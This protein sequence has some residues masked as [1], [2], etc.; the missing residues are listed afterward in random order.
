[1]FKPDTVLKLG[2]HFWQKLYCFY[3][4]AHFQSLSQAALHLN[5][6]KSSVTKA[7]QALESRFEAVL[8][9]RQNRYLGLTKVGE[10]VFD[11]MQG[12]LGT[13]GQIQT[14]MEGSTQPMPPQWIFKIPEWVFCDYLFKALD[15][16]GQPF[17]D[18]VWQPS[19]PEAETIELVD[20]SI[21]FE[22]K[23]SQNPSLIQK[24]LGVFESGIYAS[25]R[26]LSQQ[27]IPLSLSDLSRHRL[28]GFESPDPILKEHLNWHRPHLGFDTPTD[29][30]L[31]NHLNLI[32]VAE[33]DGGI[34]AYFKNHPT[35]QKS[36][37]V[38]ILQ[39]HQGPQ[40]TLYFSCSTSLWRRLEVQTF[41]NQCRL[42]FG[43]TK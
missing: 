16:F 26:T 41:Y 14:L 15:P 36:A 24:P 34:I 12:L 29:V 32:P 13:L 38:E 17:V 28:I 19:L 22:F 27:G 33:E 25:T 42:L 8:I 18:W 11:K 5:V 23:R 31:H 1:M 7:L 30:L 2:P 9:Q 3:W 43:N 40:H 4:V 20:N 21:C 37:L 39:G 10:E 35:L 6:S